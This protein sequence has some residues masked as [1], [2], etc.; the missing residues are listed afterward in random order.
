MVN[1]QAVRNVVDYGKIERRVMGRASI[2]TECTALTCVHIV[3][4]HKLA[5]FGEFDD[6]AR[7]QHIAIHCIVS[8]PR[9]PL[10]DASASVGI[11][12]I[13]KLPMGLD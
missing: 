13:Q 11:A 9:T 7:M 2:K 1:S 8:I 5:E 3:F 12:G 10:D 4:A 6:L